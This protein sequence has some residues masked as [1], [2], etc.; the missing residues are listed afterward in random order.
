MRCG[1]AGFKLS[2]PT[3][4]VNRLVLVVALVW[5]LSVPRALTSE[6]QNNRSSGR[7][8]WRVFE[9]AR[10]PSSHIAKTVA[11]TLAPR[12]HGIER[13]LN[14]NVEE[15][16]CFLFAFEGDALNLVSEG[17][18]CK[19]AR[20]VSNASVIL[21]FRDR[22]DVLVDGEFAEEAAEDFSTVVCEVGLAFEPLDKHH[23]YYTI[24]SWHFFK[25]LLKFRFF[26]LF[27]KGA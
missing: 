23:S 20:E 2:A 7:R 16:L 12:F 22:A 13:P 14:F 18:V 24:L 15:V 1:D 11:V 17:L 3:R 6:H 21:Q 5:V 19:V 25:S 26:K 27:F 4:Y 8:C 10:R 9:N